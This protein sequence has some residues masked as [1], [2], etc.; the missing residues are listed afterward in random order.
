LAITRRDF[1]TGLAAD[2]IQIQ[3]PAANRRI[4]R[5]EPVRAGKHNSLAPGGKL[6]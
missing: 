1:V 5:F 6:L 4:D 3:V 2:W